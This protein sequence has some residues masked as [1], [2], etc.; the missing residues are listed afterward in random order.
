LFKGTVF[1][2]AGGNA[3]NRAAGVVHPVAYPAAYAGAIAVGAIDRH[4]T[5]TNYSPYGDGGSGGPPTMYCVPPPR[6]SAPAIDIVAPSG[7]GSASECT[8]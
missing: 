5:V 2:F 1:V 8:L 4:G 7:Y 3:S 6:G